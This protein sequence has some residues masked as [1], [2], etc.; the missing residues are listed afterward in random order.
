MFMH[1][2]HDMCSKHMLYQLNAVTLFWL[3]KP[4]IMKGPQTKA[5]LNYEEHFK[6]TKITSWLE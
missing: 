6:E 1:R 5:V 3:H 2:S 4:P